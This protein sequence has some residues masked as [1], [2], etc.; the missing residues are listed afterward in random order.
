MEADI[1]A[2]WRLTAGGCSMRKKELGVG[3]RTPGWGGGRSGG[4][5]GLLLAPRSLGEED[6]EGGGQGHGLL[7]LWL[8]AAGRR[9]ERGTGTSSC[10]WTAAVG[11]AF[12]FSAVC[13]WV[14]GTTVHHREESEREMNE[15][16]IRELEETFGCAMCITGMCSPAHSAGTAMAL[17][18]DCVLCG[19]GGFKVSQK[20]RALSPP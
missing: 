20:R 4:C 1:R 19:G 2:S 16:V 3:L 10:C 17:P 11:S 7:P 9:R 8:D 12:A 6:D 14:P 18:Y 13:Y 5:Y 15:W